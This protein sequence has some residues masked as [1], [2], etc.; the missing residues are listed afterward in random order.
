MVKIPDRILGFLPGKLMTV[1]GHWRN[2]ENIFRS[3]SGSW[4]EKINSKRGAQRDKIKICNDFT[5]AFTGT[6]FF[7]KTFP[8]YGETGTGY[9]RATNTIM[10]LAISSSF[11][12]TGISYRQVLIS[13]G[14]LPGAEN[15]AA[16][17]NEERNILF[18]WTD[19]ADTGTAKANDKVILVAY[20]P[21]VKQV[22][23]SVDGATRADCKA[24]LETNTMR[25]YNAET[26]IGFV[27]PDEKDAA[28]SRYTG[29][30][31][32]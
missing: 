11:P 5:R 30:I 28:N 15:A 16:A 6:G 29:T 24:L 18:S 25:G 23:Y 21:A 7:N 4:N 13:K 19:N 8:S 26:W 27:S 32:L 20:F 12:H 1:T 10:N 9:N 2:G 3:A 17:D 14:L 31:Y 22:I